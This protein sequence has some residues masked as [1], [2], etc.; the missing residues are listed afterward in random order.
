[1][2]WQSRAFRRLGCSSAYKTV[3]PR[4]VDTGEAQHTL[5]RARPVTK[6][7]CAPCRTPGVVVVVY[8]M[9]GAYTVHMMPEVV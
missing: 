9:S 5:R 1:M 6:R 7:A 2:G 3:A 4:V 8:P